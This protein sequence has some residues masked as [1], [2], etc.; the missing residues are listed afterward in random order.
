MALQTWDPMYTD[1]TGSDATFSRR[2]NFPIQRWVHAGNRRADT[3]GC[4]SA[5]RSRSQSLAR[6]GSGVCVRIVAVDAAV[7]AFGR[8]DVLMNNAGVDA[9]GKEVAELDTET[10]DRSIKTN[11]YGASSLPALRAAAQADRHGARRQD[12]Q[13]HLGAPGDPQRG[14]RRL[15][16]LQGRAA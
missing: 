15:R 6:R 8:V 11:V 2:S 4:R 9:A 5:Q 13:H 16:L 3:D 14:R 1:V 10:W 12:H 7:G